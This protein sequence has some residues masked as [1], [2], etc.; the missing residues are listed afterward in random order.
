MNARM[1]RIASDYEQIKKNFANHKNIVV[2]PIGEEPAEKYRITYYVNGIYLLDDGRIETLGKHIVIIMLHAEYPRYKPICTIA[3]PIWHPNFRDGQICI[4]DIWGAGESLPDIIVNI[5]DMIQYKSWNS[6]SPLSADAA[7]WAIANKHLF[8]VGNINLWTG[9]EEDETSKKDFDI[10][11]FAEEN[12]ADGN[13]TINVTD[14]TATETP[15]STENL[16]VNNSIPGNSEG[17]NVVPIAL[18]EKSDENDFDITAEELE[19]IEFVPTATRM[20]AVSH[21]GMVKGQKINF[22]TIFMKGLLWA[23]IGGVIAFILQEVLNNATSSESV[24]K[25]MGN[26]FDSLNARYMAGTLTETEALNIINGAVRI[27]S[28]FFAAFI[29][30]GLGLLMGLGE[31]IFYGS[32]EK[33]LKYAVIGAGIS[34]GIGFVSGYIAQWMY[35]SML[36]DSASDFTNAIVRGL[37]WAIMGL[38]VGLSIGLIKP[39]KKRVLFCG[40]GGLGGGFFGGFLFN[41]IVGAV[42]TGADDTGTFARAIGIVI[43]GLLIGLGI[44]LLEQFA[45]QAWLKVIRGEFEGKEYLVFAGV[46]SIGNNGKNTIVLFKDKLVGPN[47]CDIVLE[48]S[49]YVLVDKGT[50]MGTVVNGMRV[51]RHVLR[52]GDAIA[53]GNSVLV[54]NTK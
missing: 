26:S 37:G 44:G 31:G 15:D 7:E 8:P 36:T 42:N 33:A 30:C 50:P 12:E 14:D 35:A 24:L 40:L 27:E 19:G 41:F 51:T 25:L 4:G 21:G 39:E 32:K 9:E 3:T 45:K 23:L 48:G 17:I 53:I 43:M 29:A 52:Q 20:Q 16:H 18:K 5:G 28:A 22:K 54:F 11:V 13:S 1:R 49:K 38:G 34:L 46:T 10:E 6:Y 2:E 47:H